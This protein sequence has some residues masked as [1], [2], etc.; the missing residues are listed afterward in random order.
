MIKT[1]LSRFAIVSILLLGNLIHLSLPAMAADVTFS[2]TFNSGQ[3]PGSGIL[4]A[5]QTFTQ[6]LTGSYSSFTFSSS[7]GGSI[8]V[9]DPTKVT[10][11]ATALRTRQSSSDATYTVT[12]G[13]N[14]WQ[15][16]PSSYFEFGNN[17]YGNCGDPK[18]VIRPT[19]P[20]ANWGGVGSTCNS[21]TQTLTLTFT[22]RWGVSYDVNGGSGTAPASQTQTTFGQAL[23]VATY[24]GTRT[25]FTLSGWNTQANGLGTDYAFGASISPTAA[26]IL[27]AKWLSTITYDGNTNSSGA[28]P[29]STTAVS[30]AAVTN[31]APNDGSSVTPNVPLAKTGFTFAGWNT[32]TDGTGTSYSAG[33]TTYSSTGNIT[34]Y[35][36]WNSTITYNGNGNTGGTAPTATTANGTA[37]NTT[38]ANAGTMTRTG[39]S[40]AGW[41]TAADASGTNY[42]SGLTTYQ[43]SGNITLY[44]KWT[45][46][47]TYNANGATGSPSKLNDVFINSTTP[48]IS[49]FPTIGSMVRP[50]YTF[51]GWVASA[52]GTNILTVPY[53][54]SGEVTLYAKWTANTITI[55]FDASTATSGTMASL[56]KTADTPFALPANTFLRTGYTFLNWNTAADGS[57]TTYWNAAMITLFENTTLYPQWTVLAPGAPT[58]SVA[59]GNT[60]VTVTPTAAAIS[61]GA[62]PTSSFTVTA[63]TS[64]GVA[65][66]PA[67]SCTVVSPAT[68]CLITGLT[69][70]TTYQFAATAT[71]ATNTSA[72]S[73]KVNGIPAGYVVTYNAT[74]NGGTSST[75]SATYNKPTALV[76][77]SATK[78]G[79]TFS[80]WY[81]TQTSGGSLIGAAG[82]TYTPSSATTLYARFTGIV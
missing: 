12:I 70:G 47:I 20:N 19:F 76:L 51:N 56:S 52:I 37:A 35:A 58:V 16:T 80:G 65:L 6:Q 7:N 62:G 55:I 13:G 48:T 25:G 24:S 57:G 34:L 63:Y 74:A 21:A 53:S 68:S 59:P 4:T 22:G 43:S 29:N 26:T 30:S 40:F 14:T 71:N 81:T 45:R 61:T 1:F 9:S 50:G 66:S 44:A 8:T 54:T 60:E 10:E 77:P 42:A 31:L 32:K 64:S 39:Y 41:N 28:V 17:G 36:Q 15:Y 18:F 72:S 73:A 23:T 2:Q 38:L 46:T 33:L 82:A 69:N 75:S 5:W 49:A 79:Y 3:K 67:K 27:Y 78:S 11:L